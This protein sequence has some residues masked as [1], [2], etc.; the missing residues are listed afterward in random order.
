MTGPDEEE[1]DQEGQPGPDFG[2]EA[3]EDEEEETLRRLQPLQKVGTQ[4]V[5]SVLEVG[6]RA[7]PLE[8][9]EDEKEIIIN[10]K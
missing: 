6:N 2:Q 3:A 4:L 5:P 10:K 9:E 8:D 7:P 1:K